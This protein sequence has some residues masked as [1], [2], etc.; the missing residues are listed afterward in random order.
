MADESNISVD[1]RTDIFKTR[2]GPTEVE[3]LLAS[4]HCLRV[5]A[6]ADVAAEVLETLDKSECWP[7]GAHLVQSKHPFGTEARRRVDQ[8]NEI[9]RL[10]GAEALRSLSGQLELD[11][12]LIVVFDWDDDLHRHVSVMLVA[13]GN[14]PFDEKTCPLYRRMV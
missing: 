3:R 2:T 12:K 5:L 6:H 7:R 4:G 13:E 1:R 10:A 14:Q 9:V 8:L 11:D